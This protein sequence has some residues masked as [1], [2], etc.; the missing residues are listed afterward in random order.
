MKNA[1]IYGCGQQ[2]HDNY[3]YLREYFQILAYSDSN[4]QLWGGTTN[5][6]TIIPPDK[7]ASLLGKDGIVVI[8]FG[9]RYGDI[10]R[11]CE[12][13]GLECVLCLNKYLY[14]E[15]H[16]VSIAEDESESPY[17]KMS[18]V[19]DTVQIDQE[20]SFENVLHMLELK[21][22]YAYKIWYS[23]VER[24]Q[25][26][27]LE[28]PLHNM[29]FKGSPVAHAFKQFLTKHLRG[30]ILDIGCGINNKPLY[31]GDY[32]D[33]LIYG[34][35]PLEPLP[36]KEHPFVFRK[37]VCECLPFAENSFDAIIMATSFDHILLFKESM[38]EVLRVLKN[39]GLLITWDAFISQPVY[40][41]PY[42]E[43]INTY[44]VNHLF[45]LTKEAF[46]GVMMAYGFSLVDYTSVSPY[47]E[48][49][50]EEI[51]HFYALQIH[52]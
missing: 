1:I 47:K 52:K 46:E 39:G 37:G 28:Q 5:G 22:P 3:E 13:Q 45:H 23:L 31:L 11:W 8:S 21:V 15:E 10:M 51:S 41:D 38:Q 32:P 36:G 18:F 24:M 42:S 30:T 35:D 26:V 12:A 29:S 44:D 9:K 14:D 25:Q 7:I 49:K 33:N 27:T 19:T 2:G 40:Y 16:A 34:I 17:A 50:L 43:N 4:D 20:Y 6:L 48:P